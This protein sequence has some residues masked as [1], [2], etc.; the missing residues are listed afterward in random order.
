M[1]KYIALFVLGVS[2]SIGSLCAEHVLAD[3]DF[4]KNN[5]VAIGIPLHNYQLLPIQ[6]DL[7]TFIIKDMNLMREIQRDWDLKMTFEDK[8]DHHYSLKFYHAGQLK[9]TIKLNLYCGYLSYDGLA[10]EFRKHHFDQFVRN[11]RPIDWARITFGDP[12]LLARAVRALSAT[13]DVYWYE[14][15]N[16]YLYA[17]FF[18]V[19]VKSMPWDT[20]LDSLD[21]VVKKAISIQAR[22]DDFYLMRYLTDIVKGKVYVRYKVNCDQGFSARIPFQNQYLTWRSHMANTDSVRVVAIGINRNRYQYIM[23]RS[24][25][26]PRW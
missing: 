5:W 10:Y 11:S 25:P 12:D 24:M 16:P 26:T 3:M 23:N 21:R 2:L 8:C 7:G 4:S 14:D 1:K 22:S 18:M 6:K 13:P 19:I 15:I 17:G 9:N 20:N